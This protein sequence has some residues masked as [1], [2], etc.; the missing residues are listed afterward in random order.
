MRVGRLTRQKGQDVAVR[1]LAAMQTP[2]AVLRLVGDGP[3]RAAL[4]ELAASLGLSAR[5]ELTGT[6]DD[7]APH[8]RAADVV[9]APSRWEGLSLTLLE[10]MACG[11]P[12]VASRVA[13]TAALGGVGVLVAP[14]DP[15]ALAAAADQLLADPDRAKA[16]GAAARARAVER[17]AL[18][19]SVASNL[20][21]WREVAS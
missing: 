10:A 20:A 3:D 9:I 16:C 1:A 8:L 17:F 21:L 7:T 14:D 13:G 6:V 5:I 19:D 18:E 4:L 12:I 11:A 2:G 15:T